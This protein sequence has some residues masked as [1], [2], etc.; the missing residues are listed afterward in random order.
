[1]CPKKGVSGVRMDRF[2][3]WPLH[4][5]IGLRGTLGPSDSPQGRRGEPA[6]LA[7]LVLPDTRSS[8]WLT[9]L[10][11]TG[12]Q[13]GRPNCGPP[14]LPRGNGPGHQGKAQEKGREGCSPP[15]LAQTCC[16]GLLQTWRDGWDHHTQGSLG[17]HSWLPGPTKQT[18]EDQKSVCRAVP[19]GRAPDAA[20]RQL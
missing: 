2:H 15:A 20:H 16:E 13:W 1:M 6:G 3:R 11:P 19:V 8:K 7:S 12:G 18:L 14:C 10:P 4:Q 17:T 9:A 5:S